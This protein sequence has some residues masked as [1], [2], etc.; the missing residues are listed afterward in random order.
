MS[1]SDIL[2]QVILCSKSFKILVGDNKQNFNRN[3]NEKDYEMLNE[4]N[5]NIKILYL[6]KNYRND[7][8]YNNLTNIDNC[9]LAAKKCGIYIN[10]NDLSIDNFNS[11]KTYIVRTNKIKRQ[12]DEYM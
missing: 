7:F 9:V 12:I 1:E 10:V 5:K 4:R 2:W 3:T 6:K 8:V 11:S